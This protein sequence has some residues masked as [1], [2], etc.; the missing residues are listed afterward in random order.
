M[1]LEHFLE[2][3]RKQWKAF[4]LACEQK[5]VTHMVIMLEVI[6]SEVPKVLRTNASSKAVDKS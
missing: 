3:H 2:T 6:I 4:P 5:G 1:C